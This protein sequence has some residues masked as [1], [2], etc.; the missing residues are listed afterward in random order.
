MKFLEK[1]CSEIPKDL[2]LA[3]DK[4]LYPCTKLGLMVN[5]LEFKHLNEE[6]L[7]VEKFNIVLHFMKISGFIGN[8]SVE[9]YSSF[10]DTSM[11]MKS[12]Q[13]LSVIEGLLF[14]TRVYSCL[15]P[16]NENMISHA[17]ITMENEQQ[18]NK[19]TLCEHLVE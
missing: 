5:H 2:F 10:K 9:V 16:I 7:L 11:T 12:C 4:E 14:H 3:F 6:K 8:F 15:K 13:Q 1:S 19:L 18:L 17:V